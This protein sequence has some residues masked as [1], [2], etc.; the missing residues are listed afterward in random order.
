MIK[1]PVVFFTGAG[2]SVGAGLLTY[3][4]AGGMYTDGEMPV[5]NEEDGTEKNVHK[6]WEHIDTISGGNIQPSRAHKAISNYAKKHPRQVSVITQNIDGL[7]ETSAG[8]EKTDEKIWAVHGSAWRTR[9]LNENCGE[10]NNSNNAARDK[11]NIPICTH[12][13]TRL[14][15]DIVLFGEN[16]PE[17]VYINA[18]KDIE[19]AATV[20]IVGTGLEV[21]PASQ[22]LYAASKAD[23]IWVNP[24]YPPGWLLRIGKTLQTEYGPADEKLPKILA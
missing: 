7:H 15:P 13:G 9:C 6:I 11:Q 20:V 16:L 17:D 1:T 4:G 12:C 19:N 21:A 2:I 18:Q 22:L 24:D 8:R 10:K 3:R 14:R 23:I 5:L